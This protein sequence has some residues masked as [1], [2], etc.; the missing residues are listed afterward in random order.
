MILTCPKCDSRF[1]LL[2]EVLAPEGKRVKCSNCGE[3]WFQLPD[4][5]ELLAGIEEREAEGLPS[6]DEMLEDIPD[7]VK[8]IPEGSALPAVSEEETQEAVK[9]PTNIVVVILSA[10]LMFLLLAMP[11]MIFKSPIMKAWPESI[12]FYKI[13]G[14]SGDVPGEGIVFDQMQAELKDGYFVL[15]GQLINLTSHDSVLP[16]IEVSLKDGEGQAIDYHY[17][18]MP[19]EI[20]AAEETLPITSQYKVEH[21]ENI[22]DASIRFV[23]R[24]KIKNALE[25]GDNNHALHADDHADP[26]ADAKVLKSPAHDGAQPHQESSHDSHA[27]HH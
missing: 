3:T 21:A 17:I 27:E 4:P 20:L 19:K 24:P 13:L 11:L 23:L 14:V 18:R 2:A 26:P 10:V 6:P 25:G 9:E 1:N 22:Y 16:L 15:N 5:D 12:A 7:A 8:P